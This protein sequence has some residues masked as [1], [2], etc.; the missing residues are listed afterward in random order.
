[1]QWPG[2]MELPGPDKMPPAMPASPAG[3]TSHRGEEFGAVHAGFLRAKS[4]GGTRRGSPG[5]EPRMVFARKAW[6]RS[7]TNESLRN[8]QKP[9]P[10]FFFQILLNYPQAALLHIPFDVPDCFITSYFTTKSAGRRASIGLTAA[11]GS[12]AKP[13]SDKS[14]GKQTAARSLA[15]GA[16]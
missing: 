16:A 8:L 7:S 10:D 3:T 4:R 1:M 13:N 9:C 12:S 15:D 6:T 2:I 11:G 5:S 14:A